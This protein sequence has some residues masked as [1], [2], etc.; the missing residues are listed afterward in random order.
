MSPVSM[1]Y[2]GIPGYVIFWVL[3]AFAISLF[4]RKMYQLGHYLRL[5]RGEGGFGR[6][7]KRLLST[8]VSVL[9]QGCQLKNL[10]V[11]DRASIGHAFMAWGF[12][13][14]VPFYLLF[15]ILGAGF[16][17]SEIIEDT[18]LFFYYAWVMDIAAPFGV[19]GALWGI[20]RRYIVRPSRLEGERTIEA[21][22]ILVTVLIHPITHL[23]K[24]ATAIALGYPPA[25]LSLSLPPISSAL[26]RF[27]TGSSPSSV[28]M[29]HI[30]FFWA[31]WGFVL[32]VLVFIAY[33]RYLHIVASI[34][35]ILL[36]SP[37]PKGA[38]RPL[39]L[40][41]AEAYGASRITDFTWKQLLDLY[42]CVIYGQC[43]EV[44]PATLS[45][46]PLN[47]K[48][49]IDD[50]K[51]HLLEVGPGLLNIKGKIEVSPANLGETLIGEVITEEVIWECTTCRACQQVCPVCI[52]HVDKI[53][54][55][56]R[57]LV[58]EQASMPETVEGVLRSI[59]D[60][61][62]PWRGTTLTRTDW[63]EG[64]GIKTLAEDRDIDFLFWVG[65]TEALEDRSIR[66]SQALA[67]LLKLTGVK[68]GILGDEE[69]CCGEPARRLGNEYLFQ[70]QAQKNIEILKKYNVKRIITG[71]PHCF[72]TIKNEYCQFGGEFEVF[73]HTEFIARLLNQGRLRI[74]E[75]T[76]GVVTYHD[77]CYLGRYNDI[78][79]APRQILRSLPGTTLFEME[80][81]REQTFCCGGGGGHMW[82]EERVGRR[83]N[84]IRTEQAI[85]TKAQIV[86][87]ACPFCLQMFEDGIKAKA[88]QEQFR[89]MDIA[90]LAEKSAVHFLRPE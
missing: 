6:I 73:H 25:G 89:A 85:E 88:V 16:G 66:V 1:T 12:F 18:R 63:A 23:F 69:S 53:I 15:I 61:G 37:R 51:K 5:G 2:W 42:S 39:N 3:F 17:L 72:N 78:Y 62:H 60:R 84:E 50:L 59:E 24:E 30:G 27:F 75:G 41:T 83:I 90:E 46:K 22:V 26:S 35:N 79:N 28:Q 71:C 82:L 34:F 70:F 48:K 80:R 44:C 31:H 67:K 47:P 81:N 38:L 86:V 4:V 68:F 14:F 40:E 10:A 54:D 13:I 8:A 20:I 45:G 43:Q 55:L 52:E 56:R 77:P 65:C 58:M 87:T 19:I 36:Q 33:S 7:I 32:F 9:A 76:V 29:A 57:N 64:L 11:K 49:L 21:M 74:A